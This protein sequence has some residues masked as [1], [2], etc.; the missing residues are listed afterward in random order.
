MSERIN[1]A[2]LRELAENGQGE[3]AWFEVLALVEAVEQAY[4]VQCELFS[5]EVTDGSFNALD[6]A[7]G[8]FD[9]GEAQP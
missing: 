8:R 3:V 5:G 2:Q 6:I 9:F 1:L 7:L 4:L